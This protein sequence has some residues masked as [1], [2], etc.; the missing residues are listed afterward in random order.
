MLPDLVVVMHP[1]KITGKTVEW[2]GSWVFT[3][4]RR[5]SKDVVGVISF[6]SGI[7]FGNVIKE[8]VCGGGR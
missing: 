6:H 5:E 2:K 4:R 3:V 1:R 7:C 8:I